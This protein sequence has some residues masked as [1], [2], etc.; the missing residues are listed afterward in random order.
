MVVAACGASRSAGN[1]AWLRSMSWLL[2]WQWR[3][4]DAGSIPGGCGK[5]LHDRDEGTRDLPGCLT[6]VGEAAD[7]GARIS[8][9]VCDGDEDLRRRH[10]AITVPA[11]NLSGGRSVR[12]SAADYRRRSVAAATR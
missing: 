1:G 11:D 7:K 2:R 4:E 12:R 3:G 5:S 6:A 8:N 10:R 9:R